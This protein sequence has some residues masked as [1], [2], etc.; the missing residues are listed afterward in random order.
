MLEKNG[1]KIT[2]RCKAPFCKLTRL[3]VVNLRPVIKGR[4]KL[5]T[6]EVENTTLQPKKT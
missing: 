2:K 1:L 6:Q 5:S 3:Y 4:I